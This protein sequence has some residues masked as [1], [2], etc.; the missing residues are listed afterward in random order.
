MTSSTQS[1]PTLYNIRYI[2]TT[3]LISTMKFT[4]TLL[5]TALAAIALAAPAPAPMSPV[6][7]SELAAASA[8][9]KRQCNCGACD[10]FFKS[11]LR[12]IIG[13]EV[14]ARPFV[15]VPLQRRYLQV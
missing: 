14:L 6:P 13:Q 9:N 5:I 10:D 2:Q 3:T 12:N 8:L 7:E 11:C 1:N 4:V 15:L